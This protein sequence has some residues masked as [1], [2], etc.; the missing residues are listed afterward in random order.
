MHTDLQNAAISLDESN[1]WQRL[2]TKGS[3]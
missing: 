2:T 1:C 3:I